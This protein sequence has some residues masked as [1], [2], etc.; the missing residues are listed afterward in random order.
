MDVAHDLRGK[1]AIVTGAGRGIGR[2]TARRLAAADAG[3]VVVSRTT[4]ELDETR[5]AIEHAGGRVLA[6]VADVSV[7]RDVERLVSEALTAFEGVD[8]L[9]NNAG[10]APVGGIAELESEVFDR[11]LATNVRAVYLC[12]RAVWPH[13]IRRGGGTI[14]NLSSMASFDPFPGLGAYGAAK[15]FVNVFTKALASEGAAHGIRVHAVAPGAV[16][17]AMLRGAFPGYPR[18]QT[19][20]PEAVAELIERMLLRDSRY[21]S[22]ETVTIQKE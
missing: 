2:A 5:R 9:I 7:E 12:C 18:E 22:G 4:S 15:A 19:L 8:Y 20:A 21:N 11:M 17:T 6:V 3:V 13:L 10:L 14:V 1:I 16:E